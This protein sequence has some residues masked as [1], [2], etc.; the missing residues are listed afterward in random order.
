MSLLL[1]VLLLVNTISA[2]LTQQTRQIGV[3]KA[4]GAGTGQIA[5][6]Y[7]GMVVVFGLA[8]LAIAAPLAI[9]AARWIIN[10]MAYLIDFTLPE[11]KPLAD[12]GLKMYAVFGNNDGDRALLVRRAGD[13]CTFADGA[14]SLELGGRRIVVMHYPDLSQDLFKLGTYDLVVYGHDHKARLEGDRKKLLNPGTCSGYL[15]DAAT[16]AILETDTMAVEIVR[17]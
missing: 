11:F 13:F 4:I 5:R 9:W 1:S 3:M 7:L 17:L 10:L 15:A 6:L 16:V 12:K 2:L 14:R 8:A